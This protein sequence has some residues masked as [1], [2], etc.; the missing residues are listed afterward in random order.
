MSSVT[1]IFYIFLNV[2]IEYNLFSD[3]M[4]WRNMFCF[5]LSYVTNSIY[6]RW[7]H[8]IKNT[9]F[10]YIMTVIKWAS[11]YLYKRLP[12]LANSNR[13]DKSKQNFCLICSFN[14]SITKCSSPNPYSPPG[15]IQE[16]RFIFCFLFSFGFPVTSKIYFNIFNVI[17]CSLILFTFFLLNWIDRY[18]LSPDSHSS[19][20]F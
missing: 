17:S 7:N 4:S 19:P 8:F 10:D 9:A 5:F 2:R 15:F 1:I 12:R 18:H 20:V 16:N 6:I 3:E 14:L 11:D 13:V